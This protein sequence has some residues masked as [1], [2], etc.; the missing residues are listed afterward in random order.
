MASAFKRGTTW[1]IKWYDIVGPRRLATSCTTR[2]DALRLAY[3][4][5]AKA[6]R[7]RLGL[8]A[9]PTDEKLTLWQL[10]DWWLTNYC[11][12]RSRGIERKRL[13]KWVKNTK[14]GELSLLAVNTETIDALLMQLE[15]AE[16]ANS[17]INRTR[18]MLHSFYETAR[19]KGKWVAI[20]PVTDS[21][22]RR[23]VKKK[24]PVLTAD[25]ALEVLRHVNVHWRE[26]FAAAFYLALRKGEL[27]GLKKSD[28]NLAAREIVVG[29]S[30]A[31]EGDKGGNSTTLPIPEPLVP[32]L[33]QALAKYPGEFLFPGPNGA[34]RTLHADPEKRLRTAMKL[35]GIVEGYKHRCR[36]CLG[37]PELRQDHEV[38]RCHSCGMKL[39]VSP[40]PK[41]IVFHDLR[42]TTATLLIR[43]GVH[44]KAV[45]L[46]LRHADISTTAENYVHLDL[47]DL[48]EALT[49]LPGPKQVQA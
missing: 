21:D 19:R 40:I 29:A 11:S 25:Q 36:F 39:W 37:E 47:D 27:C 9:R 12:K 23:V 1:Y 6:E 35:A 34:M 38:T 4:K 32:F 24:R 20:N 2:A 5:E 18:S 15:K 30:Y 42:H 7:Q 43:A 13:T 46:I 48:R 31:N 10:T 16:L 44:L 22:T 26:F 33:E 17:T 28:V 49:K 8:E 41:R 45:Q 3:E 14:F